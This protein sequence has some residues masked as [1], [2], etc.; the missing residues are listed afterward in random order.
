MWIC[1]KPAENAVYRHD[2]VLII[3]FPVENDIGDRQ[4]PM[5]IDADYC[6]GKYVP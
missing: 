4:R 5:N 1:A 6:C 3:Y 2:N